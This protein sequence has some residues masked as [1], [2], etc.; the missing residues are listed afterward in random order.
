[1]CITRLF[2]TL[3]LLQIQ[4]L[5]LLLLD[6]LLLVLNILLL[7]IIEQHGDLL[8]LRALLLQCQFAI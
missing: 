7:E 4:D 1:M 3:G 8:G 5:L 2:Q 6:L